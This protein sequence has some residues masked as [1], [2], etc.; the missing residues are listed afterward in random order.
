[1]PYIRPLNTD[2]E[3]D[4]LSLRAQSFVINGVRRYGDRNHK[5]L[6]QWGGEMTNYTYCSNNMSKYNPKS[7]PIGFAVCPRNK[8]ASE[9]RFIK[10][11]M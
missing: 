10:F 2:P 3:G 9:Q 4:R 7:T 1:M 6:I 5:P 8:M 11:R